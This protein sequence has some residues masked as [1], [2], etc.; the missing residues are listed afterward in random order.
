MRKPIVLSLALGILLAAHTRAQTPTFVATLVGANEAPAAYDPTA[1]GFAYVTLDATTGTV[2]YNLTAPNL[3]S[4][5]AAHIHRGIGGAAG[6]VVIPF[7]NVPLVNGYT[8]GTVTGVSTALINE[9]LGNP[10]G[11]YVNIHTTTYQGGAIRGQLGPAPGT[12]I[13]SCTPNL[14]TLC[15]SGHFKVQVSFVTVNSTGEPLSEEASAA[16]GTGTTINMTGDTGSF[17]FF[18]P[19]NVELMVKVLDG[20]VINGKYWVFFGALTDVAY[21]ITVTDLSS[22]AIKTYQ[23]TQGHQSSGN[24][25]SAF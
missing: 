25:T 12:A 18:S 17:W 24:D 13:G 3:A 22:G 14:T 11:F 23:G 6:P 2:T 10:S 19:N 9:I 15:L 4:T 20:R 21:T 7:A 1:A 5:I 16:S 8:S